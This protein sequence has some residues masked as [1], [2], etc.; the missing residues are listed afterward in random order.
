MLEFDESTV[1]EIAR[2]VCGD[3]GPLYRQGWELHEFFRRAKISDVGEY[4]GSPRRAWALR[5]LNGADEERT[6]VERA[7]LRLADPREYPEEQ[8]AFAATVERINRILILEGFQITHA[9]GRPQLIECDPEIPASHMVAPVQLKVTMVEVLTDPA[10]AAVAQQRLDEA[11]ICHANRAYMAT[12]IMLGSLLEG[13]LVGTAADRLTKPPPRPLDRIG[14][15]E[16]INLAHREGWIEVD[17]QKGSD[18]IRSYRNLVHPRAQLRM[19]H[20]PDADT[21]DMCWPIVN[22]TLNDL[23]ATR[24]QSDAVSRTGRARPPQS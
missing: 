24:P 16:L 12:I 21:V 17:V 15:Q 4:D 22:A 2:L 3:D 10:L 9:R 18:L 1:D 11:R 7:V 19:K 14:L 23:A 5:L 6:N 8:A 13:I 20:T